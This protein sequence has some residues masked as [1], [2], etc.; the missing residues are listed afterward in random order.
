MI[1]SSSQTPLRRL[2][3]LRDGADHAAFRRKTGFH[4]S[5]R[6]LGACHGCELGILLVELD[7]R[8]LFSS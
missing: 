7:F 3:R 6:A 5:Y 1:L 2:D 4:F 8:R